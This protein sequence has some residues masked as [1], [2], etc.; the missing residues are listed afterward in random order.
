MSLEKA[1]R[2]R[3]AAVLIL[4]L[5]LLTGSVIGIAVDRRLE[6]RVAASEGGWRDEAIPDEGMR[7]PGEEGGQSTGRRRLIVEQVG[8]TDVQ[9]TRVDSIV[10][11]YRRQMREL[12]EELRK[13]LETAYTP[14]Y[15]SLLEVTR[16]EIKALLTSEQRI[17]YDSL[18]AE[19]DRRRAERR[20]RDSVPDSGE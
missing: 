9:K 20:A 19:H 11:H 14:R 18:L 12:Q 8:L 4:L 15:R 2:T 7:S 3:L 16:N 13:E 1:T 6:S 17:V 10:T 5:V